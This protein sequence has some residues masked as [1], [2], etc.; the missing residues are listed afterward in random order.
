MTI[1]SPIFS[2]KSPIL[3]QTSHIF[4][5]KSI[6]ILNICNCVHAQASF[7][8]FLGTHWFA[9]F[10]SSRS[11]LDKVLFRSLFSTD[12]GLFCRDMGFLAEMLGSFVE[13]LGSL[14]RWGALLGKNLFVAF[15]FARCLVDKAVYV[16]EYVYTHAHTHTHTCTHTHMH[17]HTHTHMYTYT[18]NLNGFESTRSVID[19][20][21]YMCVYLYVYIH[22]HIYAHARTFMHAYTHAQT[23]THTWIYK[24][25]HFDLCMSVDTYTHTY[26]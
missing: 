8:E 21:T 16:C 10:E 13:M 19:K 15:E 17:T 2:Q 24:C 18:L 3:P 20:V 9:A 11:S 7:V 23:H 5:Q 26:T 25:I 4:P 6:L 22:T 12:I 14:R 1:K